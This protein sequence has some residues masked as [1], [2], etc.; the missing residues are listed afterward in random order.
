MWLAFFINYADRQVVFSLF[1]VL[2]SE[3]RFTNTELG[4]MSSTALWV[5]ACCSPIAGQ[6]GDRFSKRKV[7]VSSLVLWSIVTVLTGFSNSVPMLIGF[8][9]LLAAT[10]PLFAPVALALTASAHSPRTRSR[11]IAVFAT[12]QLAGVVMGGWYGGYIGQAFYWRLA[13]YS[14][15]VAGLLYAIPC[16]RYLSKTSEEIQLE[17]KK[18]GTAWAVLA[19]VKVPSYFVLSAVFCAFCV[20]LALLYTWLPD[21]FYEKFKLSLA[22]AGFDATVYLQIATGIGL[23]CGGMLADGLYRRTKASRSWLLCVGLLISAPTLHLIGNSESLLAVKLAALANGFG[24]GLFIANLMVASFEVVPA[25]TRASAAGVLNFVGGIFSGF[26]ALFA[27]MWKQ[28]VGMEHMMTFAGVACGAA[29][30]G[31]IAGIKV[32]FQRDYDRVH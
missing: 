10:Q 20:A 19:L 13:F 2:K 32:Y 28:S 31:L 11:A 14:L 6:L 1:P 16:W 5:Y 9:A 21:F 22:D 18:S 29:G 7:V 8:Q 4:I 23:I 30:L 26:T 24:D 15:G 27:G 12:A 3:L 25:D 17:T